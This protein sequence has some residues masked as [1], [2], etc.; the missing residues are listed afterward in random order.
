VSLGGEAKLS[1]AG[2]G[3]TASAQV[4]IGERGF[5]TTL[6]YCHS[7]GFFVGISLDGGAIVER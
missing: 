1:V 5:A 3:R 4:I 2:V 7:K 6:S